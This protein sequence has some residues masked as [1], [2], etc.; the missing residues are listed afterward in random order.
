MYYQVVQFQIQ[1]AIG[2][3]VLVCIYQQF[4]LTGPNKKILQIIKFKKTQSITFVI[5][6]IIRNKCNIFH[7]ICK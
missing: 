2:L 1:F 6:Q 4:S 5:R 7:N 3:P